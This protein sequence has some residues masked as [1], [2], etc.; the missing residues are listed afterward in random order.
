MEALRAAMRASGFEPPEVIEP[1]RFI[2]FGTNGKRHDAAGWVFLFP[3]EQ[4]A[5]FGDWRTGQEHVWQAKQDRPQTPEERERFRRMVEE[6][7]RQRQAEQERQWREAAQRAQAIWDAASPAPPNHTYLKRKQT[8]LDGLMLCTDGEF[9]GWLVV[10]V[11]GPSG[12]LQTLQFIAP[13]G[14]KRFLSGG[15]M[16]GGHCWLGEPA[17]TGPRLVCEGW[18]TAASLHQATGHP[19]CCAF[20]AGNMGNVARMVR[21]QYPAA[22][23]LVCGDDDRET[24]GNPGRTKATEAAHAVDAGVVFP[25]F[26][27]GAG[28]DF[29]DL[30]GSEGLKAVRAQVAAVLGAPENPHPL[31]IEV[32]HARQLHYPKFILPGFIAA[33]VVAIAGAHGAGKTTALVPLAL[34]AAG[35]HRPGD[36]LA[37]QHWRH[38]VYISEDVSQV[39]RIVAGLVDH[40]EIG[41]WD[42]VTKRVHLV[43]AVRLNPTYAVQVGEEYRQKWARTVDCKAGQI[44]LPPLVVF[45]TSAASFS[46]E[47]E[48]DNSAVSA[49]IAALKQAFSGLPAWVIGHVAKA[50]LSRDDLK[51]LSFRG[52][53]AWEADAHQTLFLAKESAGEGAEEMRYLVRGKSRFESPITE[54]PIL[55]DSAEITVKDEYG[56][57]RIMVLRWAICDAAGPSRADVKNGV[58]IAIETRIRG[59]ILDAVESAWTRGLPLSRNTCRRLIV[60]K[61]AS[62]VACID[63]LIQERW[64][65]EIGF[66][67]A[68][69][70]NN[71]QRHA[72]VRL[73]PFEREKLINSDVFPSRLDGLL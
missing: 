48:N 30:H 8:P 40:A 42:Q 56:N 22:R 1:G 25:K 46:M 28:T 32:P 45:D 7:K 49:V 37:P 39:H 68:L 29:N 65:L 54:L 64:L 18:A 19:V 62:V 50:S 53:S 44:E 6:A 67:E 21:E 23:M 70:I 31:S 57:D 15:R 73:T 27:K 9:R 60:G 55:S 63:E 69:R 12:A 36:L 11:R 61:S 3:D 71:N 43:E 33:G 58:S 2:R 51:T 35:I 24:D 20:N 13:D 5:T 26:S 17:G 16:K 10:P 59:D 41:T 66:P 38:V 52:A 14:G 47:N 4:G 72:L 34:T